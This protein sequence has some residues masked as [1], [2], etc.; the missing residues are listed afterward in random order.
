MTSE[1]QE[2]NILALL[3]N[4]PAF[5]QVRIALSILK[6]VDVSS[7]NISDSIEDPWMTPELKE[8]LDQRAD[9]ISSGKVQ[10]IDG[11]TFLQEL[12]TYSK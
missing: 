4:L 11:K 8:E 7:V 6:T 1:Q 2:Q 9:E 3:Q 12:R 5:Q 10:P